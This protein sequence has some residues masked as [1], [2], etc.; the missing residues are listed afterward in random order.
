MSKNYFPHY[1]PNSWQRQAKTSKCNFTKYSNL[2]LVQEQLVRWVKHSFSLILLVQAWYENYNS[3]TTIFPRFCLS[4]IKQIFKWLRGW[5][6]VQ[7]S[8][9]HCTKNEVFHEGFLKDFP[10]ET[11]D[12]VTLTE[13]IL[14][15]KLHFLGS[16]ISF[17]FGFGC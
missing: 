12:S 2:N 15:R 16:Y 4:D 8:S 11:A 14:N 3:E 7:H 9:Y 6:N 17:Q 10:Q 5:V 1:I 13:E